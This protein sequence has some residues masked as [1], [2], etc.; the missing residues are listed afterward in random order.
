MRSQ[1]AAA[2]PTPLLVQ[3]LAEVHILRAAVAVVLHKLAELTK[4]P[5]P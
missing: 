2:V 4:A 3:P 5:L 1:E